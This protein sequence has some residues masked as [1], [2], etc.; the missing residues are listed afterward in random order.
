MKQKQFQ[1]VVGGSKESAVS[2]W[3]GG[4]V[5]EGTLDV[6]FLCDSARGSENFE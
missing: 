4:S 6:L 5:K 2:I 3:L 1:R